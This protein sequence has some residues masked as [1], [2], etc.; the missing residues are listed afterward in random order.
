LLFNYYYL[1]TTYVFI[2]YIYYKDLI[3]LFH[4]N[5]YFYLIIIIN[6]L[7]TVL[8]VVKMACVA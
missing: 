3:Y 4:D 6:I 7:H 2:Q 8:G 1:I 5:N